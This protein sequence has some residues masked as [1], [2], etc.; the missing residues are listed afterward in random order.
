MV[1]AQGGRLW[2]TSQE[3]VGTTVHFTLPVAKE[4]GNDSIRRDGLVVA[5]SATRSN[6]L[7][8]DGGHHEGGDRRI[9]CDGLRH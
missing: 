5:F 7:G 1:E 4:E 3:G 8:H 6:P 2:A 9:R